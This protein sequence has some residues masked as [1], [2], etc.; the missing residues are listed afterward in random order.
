MGL[1]CRHA[2]TVVPLL[3]LLFPSLYLKITAAECYGMLFR[4]GV[5]QGAAETFNSASPHPLQGK[6]SRIDGQYSSEP[7][8]PCAL[9]STSMPLHWS[10]HAG[11]S[12]LIAGYLDDQST[13]YICSKMKWYK[14]V[15][16]FSRYIFATL[17]N[18]LSG[19]VPLCSSFKTF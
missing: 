15:P 6:R 17:W 9:R 2:A 3:H 13:A 16:S 8:Y 19:C 7:L 18:I 12:A 10:L 14:K 11:T 1:Y 5:W 4:Q